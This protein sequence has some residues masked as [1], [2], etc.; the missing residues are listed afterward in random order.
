MKFKLSLK[1][2][3]DLADIWHFSSKTWGHEQ[4]DRYIDA[5]HYRLIW[6]TRNSSAWKRRDDIHEGLYGCNEGRH[7]IFFRRY[8]EGIEI[9]RILHDRMDIQRHL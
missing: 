8:D 6:L 7:V 1:A 2:S 4:A 5:L 3:S 9:V